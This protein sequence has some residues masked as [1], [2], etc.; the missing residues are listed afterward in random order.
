MSFKGLNEEVATHPAVLRVLE[1]LKE[2][3][4]DN[5]MRCVGQMIPL[6]R[7]FDPRLFGAHDSAGI[8]G[9][10]VKVHENNCARGPECPYKFPLPT[11]TTES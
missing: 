3:C 5:S 11:V 4:A 10:L 9:A 7:G 6:L 2:Q 8:C 1:M